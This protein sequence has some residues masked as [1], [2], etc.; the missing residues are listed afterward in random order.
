MK[1]FSTKT[2][3]PAPHRL[4]RHLEMQTRRRG[5][6]HAVDLPM[7]QRSAPVVADDAPFADELRRRSITTDDACQVDAVERVGRPYDVPSPSAGAYEG[8]ADRIARR[9]HCT[10][11]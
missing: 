2:G 4:P 7:L 10:P 1:G 3:I 5:D 11:V 8:K 9:D 6:D